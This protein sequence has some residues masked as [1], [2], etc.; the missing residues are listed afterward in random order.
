MSLKDF[1]VSMLRKCCDA[2]EAIIIS[3]KVGNDIHTYRSR[4]LDINYKAQY[5]IIDEPS[6]ESSKS[7]PLSKNQKFE[8]FFK[9]NLGAGF[10]YIFNSRVL[11]RVMFKVGAR[12]IY[13]FKIFL[14]PVLLDGERR[15]YFRVPTEIKPEIIV[16]Y[17]I[18]KDGEEEP[19]INQYLNTPEIFK[20]TML[21]IS[22][23]G[24]SIRSSQESGKIDLDV[25][26]HIL[27][28]FKLKSTDKPLSLW[29]KVKNKRR[30]RDTKFFI[31]GIEFL[32]AKRNKLLKPCRNQIMRFVI[33]R[34]REILN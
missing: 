2:N 11:S 7:K 13:A 9:Y 23:G 18:Y 29:G 21:D 4:F 14:P 15:E 3:I 33:T 20:C 26:D 31:W 5:L 8:A 30:F 17:K 19:L 27:A 22:G 12:G 34:Q 32:D 10:R 6:A 28:E 16:K 24:L 1:E 25:D